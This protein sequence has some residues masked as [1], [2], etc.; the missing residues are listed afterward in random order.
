MTIVATKYSAITDD[1]KQEL[2]SIRALV[3]TFDR[4]ISGNPMVRISAANAAILLLAAT[5]EE[6]VRVMA[7]EYAKDVVKSTGRFE[8]LP[9]RLATR[10]WRRTMDTL[11]RLR[12]DS[13]ARFFSSEGVV[14]DPQ[15]R[16]DSILAFCNGDLSRDIY[17]DLIFNENNMRVG[18]INSLF[19][20]TGL[21]DV[22]RLACGRNALVEHFGEDEEGKTHGYLVNRIEGFFSRRNMIAHALNSG[23]S[24]S[25]EDIGKDIDL[26]RA[27]GQC[28][29]E[30]LE[31]KQN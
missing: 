30:I 20:V 13:A 14:L 25:P 17:D 15:A 23:A 7:K 18:E 24:S 22:C 6:Y 8:R 28:L 21:S 3:D 11:A 5:F 4:P 31:S 26:F 19:S 27:L 29:C 9:G 16:F 2:D 10:A 1:F 12:V